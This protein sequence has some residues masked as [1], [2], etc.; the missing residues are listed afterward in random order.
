[1]LKASEIK[2]PDLTERCARPE[3]EVSPVNDS[4]LSESHAHVKAK[5]HVA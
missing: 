4:A 3:I 1:M 2:R 5:E